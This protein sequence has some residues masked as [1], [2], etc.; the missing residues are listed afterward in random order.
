[1]D[2]NMDGTGPFSLLRWAPNQDIV[3]VRNDNYW[4]AEPKLKYVIIKK[5]QDVGTRLLYIKS[6]QVDSVMYPVAQRSDVA[7]NPDITLYEK[8]PTLSVTFIV[9]TFNITKS[10]LSIGDIPLTFFSDVNVRKAFCNAF[11]YKEFI[12]KVTL[13]TGLRANSP[14][15]QGLLGYDPNIPLYNYN[16]TQAAAYLK[17]AQDP[18]NPG[19]TYAQTGFHMTLYYNAGNTARQTACLMMEDAFTLMSNNATLGTT[20]ANF[21]ITVQPLDWPTFLNAREN[22]QLPAFYIGWLADY[23][24]PDDF[25]NPCLATGGAFPYYSGL[26]NA[27]LTA[28]IHAAA[29]ETNNT[30]RAQMYHN[31]SMSQYNNAYYILTAQPTAFYVFRTWVNGFIYNMMYSLY[32]YYPMSKG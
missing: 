1:M 12:D 29:L 26:D 22:D 4:R 18:R 15:V 9:M 11:N 25:A 5:V 31:I 20:G 28:M 8:L 17:L 14:I 24:D 32:Y 19:K 7:S 21:V 27:T 3:M 16:L 23:P 6:G 13:G 10:T 30:I 2:R